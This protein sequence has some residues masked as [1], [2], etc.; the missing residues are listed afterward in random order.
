MKAGFIGLGSQGP[1]MAEMI[2]KAGDELIV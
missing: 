1:G 2:A